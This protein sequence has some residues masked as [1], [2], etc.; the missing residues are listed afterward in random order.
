MLLAKLTSR[1]PHAAGGRHHGRVDRRRR[2]PSWSPRLTRAAFEGP[3]GVP[4]GRFEPDGTPGLV[5]A[6]R[7]DSESPQL[8]PASTC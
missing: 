5:V 1:W 6:L 3:A 8:G 4:D 7:L 2:Q